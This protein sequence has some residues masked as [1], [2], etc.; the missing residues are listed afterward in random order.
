MPAWRR[1]TERMDQPM[2]H[3][4]DKPMASHR[5]R[6]SPPLSS[7]ACW[8]STVAAAI[9]IALLHGCASGPSGGGSRGRDGPPAAAQTPA[10]VQLDQIPD[11]EPRVEAVRTGGPNKPYNVLGR[12]YTPIS[13]AG[14]FEER[15]LASWY[16]TKFHGQSTSSGE[17]Y[18]MFAMTAAHPTLPIPSY[19]RVRNPANGREII[20]RINDRGPFHPGRIVDLSYTGAYKLGLLRG[21]APVELQRITTDEIVAD[22]WR[23]TPAQDSTRLA[24]LNNP[25]PVVARATSTDTAASA[26]D[27]PAVSSPVA[28]LASQAVVAPVVATSVTAPS[29]APTSLAEVAASAAVT[30]P[31]VSSAEPSP[32]E[33]PVAPPPDAPATAPASESTRYSAAPEPAKRPR[34]ETLAGFWVQLGAFR[35]RPGAEALQRR[36]ATQADWISP[37]LTVFLDQSL[38]RVQAGPFDSQAEAQRAGRRVGETLGLQPMVVERR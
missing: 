18:D 9:A 20:V 29:P 15:G 6:C 3:A 37:L 33:L 23:R 34:S 35:Q 12:W 1:W 26:Q 19:A 31:V 17:P 21:V 30:A 14:P 7:G 4:T 16:G 2:D 28:S 36:T 5:D 11:A 27:A 38:F 25:Q 10:Q 22:T 32:V 13:G 8:S 24:R